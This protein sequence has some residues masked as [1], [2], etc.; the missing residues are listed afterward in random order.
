MKQNANKL[1]DTIRTFI[2]NLSRNDKKVCIEKL[3]KD[4]GFPIDYAADI[5]YGNKAPEELG[6]FE[7]F[8]VLESI[9][10][11]NRLTAYFVRN[12]ILRYQMEKLKIDV[13]DFPNKP[14]VFDMLQIT[15]NQFIGRY[16]AKELM[17]LRSNSLLDYNTNTQRV[18]TY[19][20]LNGEGT[21]HITI[22]YRAVREIREKLETGVFIPNTITLNMN[23]EKNPDFTY[24]DGKLTVTAIDG[25]DIVDGF[26]RYLAMGQIHDVNKNFDYPLE[27]RICCFP[28]NIAKQFIYQE[29][30]KTQ[31]NRTASRS[32]N[33]HSS[34]NQVINR[35]NEDS[36]CYLVGQIKSNGLLD[37]GVLA[38]GLNSLKVN[39]PREIYV[40]SKRLTDYINKIVEHDWNLAE[41]HWSKRQIVLLAYGYVEQINTSTIADAIR[42]VNNEY[43]D[44]IYIYRLNAAN[45]RWVEEVLADVQ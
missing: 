44:N 20:I 39:T 1:D 8:C 30:Q 21:Y 14:L 33:Q 28:D 41:N 16:S 22:N 32:M 17:K 18:M 6:E 7:K 13:L 4:K 24:K 36:K 10:D 25:F 45:K 26:H 27:L 9:G 19:K 29:D 42:I 43:S 12:E 15:E 5:F 40:E 34:I 37:A 11:H 3:V 31:M 23:P 35:V 2:A 38:D